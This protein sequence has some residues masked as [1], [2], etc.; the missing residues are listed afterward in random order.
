MQ[1]TCRRA[2]LKGAQQASGRLAMQIADLD[3][4]VEIIG[5]S[6]SFYAR[7]GKYYYYQI[8]VKSKNRNT[9]LQI[10]KNVPADWIINLDPVDLL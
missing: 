7:K 5:P 2:T 3:Y 9:L 1:L 6:P 4:R 10:A 8:T